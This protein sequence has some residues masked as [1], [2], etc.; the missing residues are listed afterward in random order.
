[1]ISPLGNS[2]SV[3][4]IKTDVGVSDNR[5]GFFIPSGAVNGNMMG[6]YNETARVFS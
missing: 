6:Q 4:T 5:D 2:G 3:Q 1:M